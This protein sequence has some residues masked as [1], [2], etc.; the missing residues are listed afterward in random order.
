MSNRRSQNFNLSVKKEQTKIL[1]QEIYDKF[2][3]EAVVKNLMPKTKKSYETTLL[4]F[5]EYLKSNGITYFEDVTLVEI[6]KYVI[7]KTKEVSPENA[8]RFVR[9]YKIM[10]NSIEKYFLN[11]DTSILSRISVP[12]TMKK[13]KFA[14][15][16]DD[17]EQIYKVID[18]YNNYFSIRF[19][20]IVSIMLQTGLRSNECL[21]LR[22]NDI[23]FE[24]GKIFVRAGKMRKQRKV[25]MTKAL[26]ELLFDYIANVRNNVPYTIRNDYLLLD[27]NNNPLSY[28]AIRIYASKYIVPFVKFSPH[29]VWGF[30]QLRVKFA[31]EYYTKTKDIRTLQYI[32]G[33]TTVQMTFHY[34]RMVDEDIYCANPIEVNNYL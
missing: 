9:Y 13:Q 18:S 25:P 8:K 4:P 10:I 32:M 14:Y 21:E 2:M 34:V 30:H 26:K 20:V 15:T 1:I 7:K 29:R 22:I 31:T 16:D 3:K 6:N 5:I 11:I 33:H 24:E 17:I 27:Q 19:K 23:L 28:N 12:H